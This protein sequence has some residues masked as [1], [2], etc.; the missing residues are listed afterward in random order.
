MGASPHPVGVLAAQVKKKNQNFTST[1]DLFRRYL[2]I[3]FINCLYEISLIHY[4][5][6]KY[7]LIKCIIY[8]KKVPMSRFI[9]SYDCLVQVKLVEISYMVIK[10]FRAKLDTR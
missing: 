7:I 8:I 2:L 5:F 9:Q 3:F 1:W 4:N 6:I 10:Y